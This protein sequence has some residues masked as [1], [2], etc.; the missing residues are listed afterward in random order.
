METIK[1]GYLGFGTVGGGTYKILEMNKDKIERENGVRLVSEK[2]LVR[3]VSKQHAGPASLFTTNADDIVSNPNIDVVVEVLGGVEPATSLMLKAMK[4]GKHVVTANKAALAASWEAL[5]SCAREN[6]VQL[7]YEASV[8]GGIPVLTSIQ[9]A[10]SGNEITEMLGIVNGTTN[11]IL[12]KMDEEGQSYEEALT[13]AQRLGFAEADPTADVE[14]ID[15]ANKLC[16]LMALCFGK[17]VAP[18]AIPR[19]GISRIGK[20]DIEAA[21]SAGECI[22]LIARAAFK[23][24]S[25]EYEVKPMRLPLSHPLSGVK[26]EFN[27]VFVNGNAVGELMFYGKGAGALPTGSAVVG[28]IIAIARRM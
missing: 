27:A 17:Y 12:T 3:D 26:N 1:I 19:V 4:N 18:D 21:K 13:A 20:A 16:I 11:Y 7:R 2:A 28:D 15:A 24:G 9:D 5:H 25:I 10:L 22:K 8:G 14:G 6:N 23:D